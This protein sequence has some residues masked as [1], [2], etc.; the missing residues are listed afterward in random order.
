MVL[1]KEVM[2]SDVE[3][4]CRESTVMEAAQMMRQLD[5]GVLPVVDNGYLVGIVTDRDIT[6][7]AVAAGKIPTE[8]TVEE[9]MTHDVVVCYEEQTLDQAG[10]L[11]EDQ[12]IRRLLI[13]NR[14]KEL[15]GVVSLGDLAKSRS[16]DQTTRRTLK[17]ISQNKE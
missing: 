17:G 1:C 6:I 3:S 11:M 14:N 12:Q 9:T 2:T 4:I 7:R 13:V 15:V 16:D 8:A 10:R 5:V